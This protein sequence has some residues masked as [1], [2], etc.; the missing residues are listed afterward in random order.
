MAVPNT[1][2]KFSDI[3]SEPNGTYSSGILSMLTMS[4]FSYFAGPNGSNSLPD[5]N[6]GVSEGA[7]VNRIYGLSYKAGP[8]FGYEVGDYANLVYYYDNSTYQVT[9][10]ITNNLAP[11]PFP[12]NPPGSN[13]ANVNIE[14]WDDGFNYQYLTGGGMAAENGGTYGPASVSQTN[15]PIIFRGYWKVNVGGAGPMFGGGSCDILINGN[16]KVTGGAVAAG[17]GGSTFDSATY[18]T[19]DVA[20]Y[21]GVIGLDF[22]IT[23]Y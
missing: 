2:I 9:L 3:W 10:N 14:L 17:P 4:F 15:D 7:G 8:S 16:T 5:N 23:V 6:W 1:N 21:G 12:P 20:S 19:E 13:D 22:N 18:G 11:L